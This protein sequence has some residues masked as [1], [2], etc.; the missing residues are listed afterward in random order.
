[1]PDLNSWAITVVTGVATGAVGTLLVGPAR[2]R[3]RLWKLSSGIELSNFSPEATAHYRIQVHN[4]GSEAIRDAIAYLTLDNSP[5]D[6]V[7]GRSAY[8]GKGHPTG[9]QDGRLCWAIGGNPHR[10]DIYPGEKQLLNFAQI[11]VHNSEPQ[12]VIASE[13]GFGDDSSRPARV[14]LEAKRYTGKI[15]IVGSNILAR[16]FSV[17][18]ALSNRRFARVHAPIPETFIS[19]YKFVLCNKMD[20]SKL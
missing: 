10:I 14:C 19:R 11:A 17:E 1:M 20:S 7:D 5:Q 13:V 6:I 12:V 3:A 9:V 2:E 8:E 16:S 18:I 4:T 15:K